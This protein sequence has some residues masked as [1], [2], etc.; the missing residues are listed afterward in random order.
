MT[1]Q[2]DSK[3]DVAATYEGITENPD[4]DRHQLAVWLDTTI[5]TVGHGVMIANLLLIA[6]IVTQVTLRY[7]FNLNFP[8]IDELQRH[9]YGL[10]TVVGVSYALTTDSHVRVEIL[11]MQS[12]AAAGGSSRSSGSPSCSRPSST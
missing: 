10:V 5:K 12:R 9:I 3:G 11:H 2:S 8:K 1:M 6:A 7:A 4:S